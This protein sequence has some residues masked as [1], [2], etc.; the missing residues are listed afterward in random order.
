MK[1]VAN[2]HNTPLIRKSFTFKIHFFSKICTATASRCR[3][4]SFFASYPGIILSDNF[5]FIALNPPAQFRI[6]ISHKG[7][8]REVTVNVKQP[9]KQLII[10]CRIFIDFS[11][12]LKK[13]HQMLNFMYP[14][15]FSDIVRLAFL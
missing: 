10:S 15:L 3:K 5:F 12:L 9:Q 14:K 7:G 11:L 13:K 2:G 1:D 4:K 8:L 6:L